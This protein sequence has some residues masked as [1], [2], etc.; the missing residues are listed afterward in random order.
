MIGFTAAAIALLAGSAVAAP[1]AGPPSL[2]ER[3]SVD[4]LALNITYQS[5]RN[6]TYD[7]LPKLLIMAT[8]D[9]HG[10]D[11]VEETAFLLDMTVNCG[12]PVVTTAAMRPSSAISADGPNNLLQAA[13]TAVSPDS[14]DRGALI[15]LNDRICAAYYCQ[16]TQANTVDT[17]ESPEQGS[18]GTLLSTMPFYYFTASQPTFKKTFD[19]SNVTELPPVEIFYGYQGALCPSGRGVTQLEPTYCLRRNRFPPPQRLGRGGCEGRGPGRCRRRR[20]TILPSRLSLPPKEEE[21]SGPDPPRAGGPHTGSLA[22]AGLATINATLAHGIP[23]VRSSKI[24][25]GFVVPGACGSPLP[26]FS[27]SFKEQQADA[28]VL[29]LHPVCAWQT[30]ARSPRARSTR[31][32]RAGCS[33]SCSRPGT[34]TPRS[35]RRSKRRSRRSSRRARREEHPTRRRGD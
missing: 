31:S 29:V 28:D 27:L 3:T 8:G 17:F 10:T 30:R 19:L 23:V 5:P 12:K 35:A 34:R 11:T 20:V 14:R 2:I 1:V 16:K 15:V 26:L 9:T 4:T 6:S 24:N 22:S 33:R 21:R 32:R 13:R 25:N 18:I 7:H